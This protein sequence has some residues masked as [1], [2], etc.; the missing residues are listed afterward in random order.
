MKQIGFSLV[1]GWVL[2]ASL[3]AQPAPPP[4]LNTNAP[5]VSVAPT[6]VQ[7]SAHSRIWARITSQTNAAGQVTVVTNKA[8]TEL[9]SGLCY[10]QNGQWLDSVEQIDIVAGGASATQARH[11]VH[12]AGNANTAGGAIHLVAPS[13]PKIL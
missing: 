10:Q 3:A 5:A 12:F 13:S 6:I 8:Y 7:R 9:A 1:L 4:A 2:Q 11:K